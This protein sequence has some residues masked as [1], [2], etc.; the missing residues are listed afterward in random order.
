MHKLKEWQK[1]SKNQLVEKTSADI[2]ED[3]LLKIWLKMP[4]LAK[5]GELLVQRLI[6]KIQRNLTRPVKFVVIY[7]TYRKGVSRVQ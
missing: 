2:S 3:V 1:L 4:F 7:Q 6:K 5:Q